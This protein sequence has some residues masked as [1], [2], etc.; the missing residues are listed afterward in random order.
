[1]TVVAWLDQL[2]SCRT[3]AKPSKDIVRCPDAVARGEH[4]LLRTRTWEAP[5][6]RPI[7]TSR[8]GVRG[9][10]NVQASASE[11]SRFTRSSL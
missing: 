10:A 11:G 4:R 8:E 1:M 9:L 5:A 7:A 3:G 2:R 6:Q